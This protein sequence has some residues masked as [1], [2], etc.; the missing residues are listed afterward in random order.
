MADVFWSLPP[1][2]RTITAG[3]VTVSAL[4]YSGLINFYNYLFFPQAIFTT[5]IVPQIWRFF[6]AFMITKPK[7]AILL[8]PYFRKLAAPAHSWT[9]AHER[10]SI[11]VWQRVGD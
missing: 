6:T 8:D 4:G 5:R 10:V 2:T 7:F 9:F 11:P 3:A 1:V